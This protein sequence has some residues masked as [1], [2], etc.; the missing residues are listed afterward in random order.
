[1]IAQLY[2]CINADDEVHYISSYKPDVVLEQMKQH[3]EGKQC[4]IRVL[5]TVVN[6]A[7]SKRVAV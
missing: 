2:L 3:R 7:N 4:T 1:M 6:V 5:N